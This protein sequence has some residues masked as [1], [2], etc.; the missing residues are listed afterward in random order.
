M[1]DK[2]KLTESRT[3]TSDQQPGINISAETYKI[4]DMIKALVKNV[5]THSM[6]FN[7]SS[8]KAFN[9]ETHMLSHI[10]EKLIQYSHY[11]SS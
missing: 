5:H 1:Y 2:D 10:L 8:T 4:P 9:G 7:F 6:H 11:H 3:V